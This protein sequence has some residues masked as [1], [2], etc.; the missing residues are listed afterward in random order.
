MA[1]KGS[2]SSSCL[3]DFSLLLHSELPHGEWPLVPTL[4]SEH[5]TAEYWTKSP[6]GQQ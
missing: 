4:S 2:F 3:Y 6:L 1:G 5:C